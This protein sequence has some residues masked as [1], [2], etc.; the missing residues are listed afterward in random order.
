LADPRTS[1]LDEQTI[2][3]RART[4]RSDD[5]NARH[6]GS[7]TR[8]HAALPVHLRRRLQHVQHLPPSHFRKLE[9]HNARCPDSA[10]Q[11]AEIMALKQRLSA[12][13]L[14]MQAP[15]ALAQRIAQALPEPI[16]KE[17]TPIRL[18]NGAVSALP[19]GLSH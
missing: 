4:C 15:T 1:K 12:P 2:E 8:V 16:A 14:R 3:L 17:P 10:A 19:K 13:R 18:G 11:L 5:E 9:S 7:V 6:K